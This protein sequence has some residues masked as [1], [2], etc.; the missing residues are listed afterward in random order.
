[1]PV[2][3]LTLREA[4][5]RAKLTQVELAAKTGV[6]QTT[7]SRLEVGKA[8]DPNFS[9]VVRIAKALGVRPEQLV[10]GEREQVA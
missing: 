5:K 9:T 10:F 6:L 3:T 4:R 1:M 7:I 8:T 2:K